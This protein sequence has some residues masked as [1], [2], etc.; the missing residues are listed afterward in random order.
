[1]VNACVMPTS[2]WTVG[3]TSRALS[4]VPPMSME[5][6]LYHRRIGS[7]FMMSTVEMTRIVMI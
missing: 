4:A 1:M 3:A 5:M 7:A 2:Q 6:V